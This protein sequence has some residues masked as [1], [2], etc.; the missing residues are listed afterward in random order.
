[1]LGIRQT[2]YTGLTSDEVNEHLSKGARTVL[3]TRKGSEG[4]WD[5]V[6]ETEDADTLGPGRVILEFLASVDAGQLEKGML[7]SPSMDESVGKAALMTL[8]KMVIGAEE[9]ETGGS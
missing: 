2:L 1:M 9:R 6:F 8:A 4:L 7:D 5:A 3:L